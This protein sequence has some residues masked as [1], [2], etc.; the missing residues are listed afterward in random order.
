MLEWVRDISCLAWSQRAS[1]TGSLM[2]L[3]PQLLITGTLV[4]TCRILQNERFLVTC[5]VSL[6]SHV[7]T[8]I[9]YPP[10]VGF[11]R[12]SSVAASQ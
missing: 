12:G 8:F 6:T 10:D 5:E 2:E 11:C 7:Q 3:Q 4:E 9:L 1:R